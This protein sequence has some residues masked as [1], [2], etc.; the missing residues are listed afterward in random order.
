MTIGAAS[1]SMRGVSK[2]NIRRC[3][4]GSFQ[5]FL[6][7]AAAFDAIFVAIEKNPF[8]ASFIAGACPT[9]RAIRSPIELTTELFLGSSKKA[10][11]DH[12]GSLHFHRHCH[13]HSHHH[14]CCCNNNDHWLPE[15]D[16][17][18]S[19]IGIPVEGLQL[20]TIC[21]LLIFY[22]HHHHHHHHHQIVSSNRSSL[23]FFFTQ[24]NNT[25]TQANIN[26]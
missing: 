2:A 20:A 11:D 16:K 1:E 4:G 17:S 14:H 18:A 7:P 5:V 25:I 9:A 23:H 22:H 19:G 8:D 12:I 13:Q 10:E 6:S 26:A 24:S 21:Q 3:R 15:S